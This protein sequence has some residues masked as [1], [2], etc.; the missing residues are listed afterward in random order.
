MSSNDGSRQREPLEAP[1]CGHRGAVVLR[2][3]RPVATVTDLSQLLAR[4]EVADL[5]PELVPWLAAAA[6]ELAQASGTPWR[7]SGDDPPVALLRLVARVGI[8]HP[9][10]GGPHTTR[11]V[12]LLRTAQTGTGTVRPDAPG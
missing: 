1:P 2:R 8:R 4:F 3:L 12:E 6:A 11:L 9:C 7:A 10:A 5:D